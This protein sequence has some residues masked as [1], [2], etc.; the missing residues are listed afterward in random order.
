MNA[1]YCFTKLRNTF[2]LISGMSLF[3]SCAHASQVPSTAADSVGLPP[4]TIQVVG[5]VKSSDGN[6]VTLSILTI[7]GEGQGIINTL[8]EGQEVRVATSGKMKSGKGKKIEAYLKEE[9]NID[10]SQSSYSLLRYKE[11]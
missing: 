1:S 5:Y 11:M 9:L 4:S 7:K 3:L 10:A 8:S 6:S 2:M